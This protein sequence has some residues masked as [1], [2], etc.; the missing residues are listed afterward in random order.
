MGPQSTWGISQ[1]RLM[2]ITAIGRALLLA[3][4]KA[5]AKEI[6]GATGG[7]GGAVDY[8][9]ILNKPA[10]GNASLADVSDI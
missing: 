9:D 7:G 10:F 1:N 8:A 3:N 6:I 5:T 2:D 4:D